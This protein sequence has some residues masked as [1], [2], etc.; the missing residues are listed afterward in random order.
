VYSSLIS[1]SFP[2]FSSVLLKSELKSK[3][4]I[5]RGMGEGKNNLQLQILFWLNKK[6]ISYIK[7]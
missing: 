5:M 4:M 6:K 2:F 1:S 3:E 7:I